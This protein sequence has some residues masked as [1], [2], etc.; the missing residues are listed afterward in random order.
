MV[1]LSFNSFEGNGR[2]MKF[3][4]LSYIYGDLLGPLT[5]TIAV[6]MPCIEDTDNMRV[7]VSNFKVIYPHSDHISHRLAV[8]AR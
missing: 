8:A 2:H 5:F 1:L 4:L 7:P 6:R 3:Q